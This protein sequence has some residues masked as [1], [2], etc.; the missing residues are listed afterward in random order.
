MGTD[1][2]KAGRGRRNNRKS[3]VAASNKARKRTE[4]EVRATEYSKL[5]NGQRLAKLDRD[6]FVATKQ[7]ARIMANIA[8]GLV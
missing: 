4:A 8:K 5:T 3:G 1:T 6:G 7:R 2:L